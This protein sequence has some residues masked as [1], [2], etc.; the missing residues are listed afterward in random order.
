LHN[1]RTRQRYIYNGK[2]Q[3]NVMLRYTVDGE[4]G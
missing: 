3:W 2:Q 4:N 1:A